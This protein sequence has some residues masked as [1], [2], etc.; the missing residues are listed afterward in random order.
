[1]VIKIAAVAMLLFTSFPIKAQKAISQKPNIIILYA[2]DL[3]YGDISCNG[4]TKIHTPN[5]DRIANEGLRFTN[6]HST[7]S[8]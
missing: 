2:D 7:A 4:A 8:T 6:A 5:I 3:G 1:M